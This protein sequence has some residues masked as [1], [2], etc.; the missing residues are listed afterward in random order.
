MDEFSKPA[1][2]ASLPSW[3]AWWSHVAFSILSS[4][5]A[6]TRNSM[7][8]KLTGLYRSIAIGG[9]V[10]NSRSQEERSIDCEICEKKW[11]RQSTFPDH[12][13]V[14]SKEMPFNCQQGPKNHIS[15]RMEGMKS[16]R[17][18]P[19]A[20]L[21]SV[22][23]QIHI[24]CS[25]LTHFEVHQLWFS[26]AYLLLQFLLIHHRDPFG[27]ANIREWICNASPFY[28][29]SVWQS[30]IRASV[31]ALS[32]SFYKLWASLLVVW[33]CGLILTPWF[34]YSSPR[35]F[36]GWM[37]LFEHICNSKGCN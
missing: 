27:L 11:D 34:F 23:W 30:E 15:E 10:L 22:T 18:C 19:E 36:E 6:V 29:D 4:Q 13:C 3:A 7:P 32:T 5:L 25:T 35:V 37:Y 21:S 1:S 33:I 8:L 31:N 17:R 28:K 12:L 20:V 24:P 9:R 2:R 14:H 26:I 16:L